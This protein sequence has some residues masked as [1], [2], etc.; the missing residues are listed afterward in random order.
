MSLP[1]LGNDAWN[2]KLDNLSKRHN[3]PIQSFDHPDE[4]LFITFVFCLNPKPNAWMI[5]VIK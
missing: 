3:F 1:F 5:E 4:Q 2:S